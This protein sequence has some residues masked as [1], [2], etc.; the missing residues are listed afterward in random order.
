M[1]QKEEDYIE[2]ILTDIMMSD[3]GKYKFKGLF[4][5]NDSYVFFIKEDGEDNYNTLLDIDITNSIRDPSKIMDFYEGKMSNMEDNTIT[6]S[7]LSD[8]ANKLSDKINIDIESAKSL[9]EDMFTQLANTM[10]YDIEYHNETLDKSEYEHT[11]IEHRQHMGEDERIIHETIINHLN[12]QEDIEIRD[13]RNRL[14]DVLRKGSGLRKI[15]TLLHQYLTK[16]YHIILRKNVGGIYQLDPIANGYSYKTHDD[17][18]TL[19]K[20]DFGE[21]LVSD[22]DLKQAITF[23]GDRLEPQYNIVKFPNCIYDMETME[24]I[25]PTEPVFTLIESQYNY[26]PS[27]KSTILKDFLYSSLARNTAEETEKV[28]KG[29]KQIV[30]YFFTSGNRLNIIPILTGVA[31]GGKSVFTNILTSIFGSNKISDVSFQEMENNP[32]GTSALAN[33]HLNFIRD[34]DDRIIETNS[35]FNKVMGYDDIPCNPKFKDPYMLPKDEVPKTMLICN[36][37]PKFRDYKQAMIERIVIIEF[38]IK[39]RGT[40]KQDPDLER[41]ILD[42]PEEIEWLIYESLEAYKE[43]HTQK[44]FILKM[45]ET[46][47]RELVDKHTNPI[48]FLLQKLILKHDPEAVREDTEFASN[49][50]TFVVTDELLSVIIELS[51]DYGVD[52]PL[53]TN[54]RKDKSKLLKAIKDEFDLHDGEVIKVRDSDGDYRD[55]VRQYKTQTQRI[56]G[57]VKRIYPNLMVT[58]LYKEKLEQIKQ[59][60]N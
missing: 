39:F 31:G 22:D 9:L 12:N 46:Q 56:N 13:L 19:L 51:K 40:D 7:I 32:H 42:N 5:P 44:D 21:D 10:D 59:N 14:I 8:N 34:S 29:L 18:I 58:D 1:Y 17:I 38:M 55:T 16:K 25:E 60:D 3:D 52:V 23:I 47:T 28:I 45:D 20:D 15:R 36:N 11:T 26:N 41:K 37:I 33:K 54:N 27:A 57:I 43:I 35:F 50:H 53:G 24:I 30:G 6:K 4:L 48:N 49:N 2:I